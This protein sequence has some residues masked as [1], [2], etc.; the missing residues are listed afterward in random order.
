MQCK[1]TSCNKCTKLV[2]EA[3]KQGERPSMWE[4]QDMGKVRTA[5][6]F[7]LRFKTDLELYIN[8]IYVNILY[9]K[10]MYI[11]TVMVGFCY[12]NRKKIKQFLKLV[13]PCY[14]YIHYVKKPCM[15]RS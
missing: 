8:I 5:S 14:S 15:W 7:L 13:N 6:Q 10:C 12:N 3:N 11:P 9:I 2:V 4:S 1:F